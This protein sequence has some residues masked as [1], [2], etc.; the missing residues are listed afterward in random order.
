[1]DGRNRAHEATC[2]RNRLLGI[3][4]P[5]EVTHGSQEIE[6]LEVVASSLP[7]L[8]AAVQSNTYASARSPRVQLA[9]PRRAFDG[10]GP[11]SPA[12]RGITQQLVMSDVAPRRPRTASPAKHSQA[13]PVP[14]RRTMDA[15]ALSPRSQRS[16]RDGAGQPP[17][18][19]S[20][21][22]SWRQPPPSLAPMDLL[23]RKL[24]MHCTPKLKT[25]MLQAA[26]SEG[27]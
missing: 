16:Y 27:A 5:N 11:P 23:D 18:A 6:I 17:F 3:L 13:A 4:R 9:V 24:V 25:T 19:P 12:T 15:L 10:H 8:V 22:P 21:V 7:Q 14:Q 26:L 20:M 2:Q 1:M